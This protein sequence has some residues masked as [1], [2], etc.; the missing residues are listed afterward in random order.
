VI[1][2]VAWS[3]FMMGDIKMA[4]MSQCGYLF[5]AKIIP[6]AMKTFT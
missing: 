6:T 4:M 1:S 3:V 2:K 5:V